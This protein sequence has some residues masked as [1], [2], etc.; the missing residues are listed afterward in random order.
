MSQNAPVYTLCRTD[1]VEQLE[2]L[3]IARAR[4]EHQAKQEPKD[5]DKE[6][7]EYLDEQIKYVQERIKTLH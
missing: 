5:Y 7:Y 4:Y 6:V 2:S 1:L 3:K